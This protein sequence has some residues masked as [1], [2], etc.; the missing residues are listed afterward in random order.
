[1]LKHYAKDVVPDE[2]SGFMQYLADQGNVFEKECIDSLEEY[3]EPNSHEQTIALM[4][5]G[6]KYIYQAVFEDDKRIG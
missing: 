1:M 6:V 5:K 3:S 4:E 2:A